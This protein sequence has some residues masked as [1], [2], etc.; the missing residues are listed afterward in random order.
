MK[1]RRQRKLRLSL[2]AI[3]VASCFALVT[4]GCVAGDIPPILVTSGQLE[5]PPSLKK[6][7]LEGSVL[8]EYDV[9]ENGLVRNLRVI[10][11]SP[12][13]LFDA[14]ALQ[15]VTTWRFQPRKRNGVAEA[16]YRLQ[17]RISFVLGDGDASYEEFLR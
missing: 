10:E 13:G 3:G 14:A 12:P 2:Y 6:E 15:F 16:A 5:Y 17:S 11:S 7:G 1:S 8:V 4:S 9:D